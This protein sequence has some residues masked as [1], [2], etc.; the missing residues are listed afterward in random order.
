M[1]HIKTDLSGT[2]AAIKT[3]KLH[4]PTGGHYPIDAEALAAHFVRAHSAG[5]TQ[6]QITQ[7][8]EAAIKGAPGSA[9]ILRKPRL[10]Q[11]QRMQIAL[12]DAIAVLPSV[13]SRLGGDKPVPAELTGSLR[14]LTVQEFCP[15]TALHHGAEKLS[16]AC[17]GMLLKLKRPAAEFPES[18]L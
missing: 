15:K 11:I 18:R 4:R 2:L 12:G 16:R 5:A 13:Q 7:A 9:T 1:R 14:A 17:G 6:E 3:F 8:M 10:E